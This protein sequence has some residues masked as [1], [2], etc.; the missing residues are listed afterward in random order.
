MS[1]CHLIITIRSRV[2]T[3]VPEL[4]EEDYSKSFAVM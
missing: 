2:I 4:E 3:A 1:H